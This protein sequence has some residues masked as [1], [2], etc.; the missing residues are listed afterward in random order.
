MGGF[1]YFDKSP[2]RYTSCADTADDTGQHHKEIEQYPVHSKLPAP[3]KEKGHWN[4]YI[5]TSQTQGVSVPM[6]IV[7]ILIVLVVVGVCLW[8]VNTYIPMAAPI[9]TIINVIVVLL[10]VVWLLGLFGLGNMTIPMRR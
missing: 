5:S 6:P 2:N 4:G 9:K 8:L 7:N 10:L 1:G 3:Q